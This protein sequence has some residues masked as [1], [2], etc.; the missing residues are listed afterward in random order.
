MTGRRRSHGPGPKSRKYHHGNLREAL[1]EA[2]LTLIS[3]RGPGGFSFADAARAAGVSPAA[4]YR[5]FRD[6]EALIAAVAARG[7]EKLARA[8]T[9]AT[10][11]EEQSAQATLQR[12]GEAYLAF[13]RDEPALF[14]AMYESGT[15][16]ATAREEGQGPD[17]VFAV[18]YE[19]CAALV[20]TLASATKPPAR[21]MA[22][23]VTS[24]MHG[25]ASLYGRGDAGRQPIP[26]EPAEL[27]EAGLLIYLEGLGF[28]EKS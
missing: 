1:I 2:A 17:A 26:M 25:I 4:P 18:I 23:H 8:L 14:A 24:V 21:M 9:T 12:L 7:F 13:A 27:L 5:H 20:E 3:D 11:G 28:S 22:L 16:L 6:R 10:P 19:V 15:D